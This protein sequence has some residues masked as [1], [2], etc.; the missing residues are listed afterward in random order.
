MAYVQEKTAGFSV[1]GAQA[2]ALP[3]G[4][5]EVSRP[6]DAQKMGTADALL[7]GL[8]VIYPVVAIVAAVILGLHF[9]A[10]IA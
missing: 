6:Q 9:V 1:K 7:T 8:L 4:P 5:F 10:P 2:A 3:A